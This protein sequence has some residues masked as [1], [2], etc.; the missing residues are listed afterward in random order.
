MAGPYVNGREPEPGHFVT[1]NGQDCQ[2]VL[3]CSGTGQRIRIGQTMWV[4]EV[5]RP[6]LLDRENHWIEYRAD[7]C[8]RRVVDDG[9]VKCTLPERFEFVPPKC[10]KWKT[11]LHLPK[12]AARIT[13]QIVG[14]KLERLHSI[15]T[16]GAMAEGVRRVPGYRGEWYGVLDRL[17]NSVVTPQRTPRDAFAALWEQIHGVPWEKADQWVWVIQFKRVYSDALY[18]IGVWD[19]DEQA[20][21]APDFLPMATMNISRG[22]LRAAMHLLR[23]RGFSVHRFRDAD[24]SHDDNDPQVMIE[25]TGGRCPAR[26]LESWKR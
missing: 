4:R 25:R 17:G 11:S 22:K 26:I 3:A 1:G 6:F 20:F 23:D 2:N 14:I 12:W 9:G 19:M 18:S 21:T 13:C 5:W 24:G 8:I 16:A 15:D 7:R 10:P